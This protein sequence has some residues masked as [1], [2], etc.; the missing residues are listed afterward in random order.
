MSRRRKHPAVTYEEKRR[1]HVCVECRFSLPKGYDRARCADCR[2]AESERRRGEVRPLYKPL[3]FV[4]GTMRVRILRAAARHDWVPS[5]ELLECI[6]IP[7]TASLEADNARQMLSRLHR[8]RL[9]E[10]EMRLTR[11]LHD[12]NTY[13]YHI[14]AKG[15]AALTALLNQPLPVANDD[16]ADLHLVPR[17][18]RA[19]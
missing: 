3:D 6:G 14:T 12:G 1:M 13:W 2:K 18:W 15:R 17:E 8:Q 5:S 4:L 9:L 19:A 11:D 16:E 10:R 7:A